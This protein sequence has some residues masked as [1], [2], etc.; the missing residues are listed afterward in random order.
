MGD[1][2]GVDLMRRLSDGRLEVA[3][4]EYLTRSREEISTALEELIE[5]GARIRPLHLGSKRI[6]WARGVHLSERKALKRWITDEAELIEH[7]VM[8]ATTLT[9]DEIHDLSLVELRSITRI[10]RAMTESD[11]KLYTYVSAFVTTSISEQLWFARGTDL[12]AFHDRQVRLPDGKHLRIAV[13]SDQ[14]RLWATLCNYRIQAK[15]QLEASMNAVL[16]IRPLVGKGADAIANDLKS[17]GRGLLTDALEPWRESVQF[18]AETNYEDGWAHSEDNSVEG[19]MRELRNMASMDKHEQ[20]W[21]KFDADAVERETAKRDRVEKQIERRR[22]L[23][24]PARLRHRGIPG[25][26]HPD[27]RR[28]GSEPAPLEHP[29]ERRHHRD[30]GGGGPARLRLLL[31]G[32]T[33]N[34]V[35]GHQLDQQRGHP[36]PRGQG[37]AGQGSDRRNAKDVQ[38]VLRNLLRT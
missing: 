37:P 20:V 21:A 3:P 9:L 23:G 29:H 10:V 25:D 27:R 30:A 24:R 19:M 35:A 13:A 8:L 15:Q 14:A 18:R 31:R 17:V 11:L 32:Q 1:A 22:H 34:P 4:S 28:E 6:G 36:A 38:V 7:T 33:G 5:V 16:T 26:H 12:T 2:I